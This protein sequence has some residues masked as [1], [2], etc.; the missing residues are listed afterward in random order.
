[1]KL[2]VKECKLNHQVLPAAIVERAGS[3]PK[4]KRQKGTVQASFKINFP[5]SGDNTNTMTQ[6]V[7]VKGRADTD[8]QRIQLQ[9]ASLLDALAAFRCQR[10]A[11]NEF[12]IMGVTM[13]DLYDET[14]DLFCAGF[15]YG[16]SKVA[17]F[18][19][20]R[21]HPHLKIHPLNWNEYGYA[22]TA[23][24]YSYYNDDDDQ[25][26]SEL[27]PEPPVALND[28]ATAEFLRRSCNLLTHELGHLYGLG[29][30]IFNKCLMMGTAHLVEDF[31]A[32]SYLCPVCLRKLQ[33][34]LGFDVSGRYALLSDTFRD[35]GLKKETAWTR[36]QHLATVSAREKRRKRT[37]HAP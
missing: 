30:C 7:V 34:R 12:C 10:C 27:L 2:L 36:K 20:F 18:S 22:P 9:V 33:C 4:K 35:M 11:A 19:F 1:M 17:V 32:P 28:G 3:Q 29:H 16:G 31:S 15:A 23:D 8:S 21:Y 25:K 24:F 37:S 6:V 14:T 5:A 13:E 26:P